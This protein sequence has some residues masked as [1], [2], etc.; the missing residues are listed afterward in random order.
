MNLGILSNLTKKTGELV[1]N[2]VTGAT[3]GSLDRIVWI[4]LV[5]ATGIAL[6]FAAMRIFAAESLPEKSQQE[7]SQCTFKLEDGMSYYKV[8]RLTLD[9]DV[10]Y[11]DWEFVESEPDIIMCADAVMGDM[12][13]MKCVY[14]EEGHIGAKMFNLGHAP[15]VDNGNKGKEKAS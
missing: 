1:G 10:K 11:I 3:K 15:K 6:L 9:G 5:L 12:L 13:I 2:I 14:D 4:V 8:A 7:I